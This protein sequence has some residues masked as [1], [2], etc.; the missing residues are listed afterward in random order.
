[1][2]K[3]KLIIPI[4]MTDYQKK[5]NDY[6]F[7]QLTAEK[8]KIAKKLNVSYIYVDPLLQRFE[9]TRANIATAPEEKNRI[10]VKRKVEA[11]I[12]YINSLLKKDIDDYSE[13]WRT[14]NDKFSES[15]NY[16]TI[17]AIRIPGKRSPFANRLSLSGLTAY[18][19][20]LFFVSEQLELGADYSPAIKIAIEQ[21]KDVDKNLDREKFFT[22]FFLPN[23]IDA[24][25][26]NLMK[27]KMINDKMK[28]IGNV[29]KVETIETK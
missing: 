25:F 6:S 27:D 8:E 7:E 15:T 3:E 21:E 28:E 18:K 2:N 12:V 16:H 13:F 14:L 20:F 19:R 29:K 23:N 4:N 9:T 11:L 22:R 24:I 1:M 10:Y 26:K 5:I 17:S